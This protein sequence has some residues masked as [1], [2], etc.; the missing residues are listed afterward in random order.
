MLGQNCVVAKMLINITIQTFMSEN[1]LELSQSR[2]ESS[3]D[4]YLPRLYTLGLERFTTTRIWNKADKH[5]LAHVWEYRDKEAMD[6]CMPIWSEIE[7]TWRETIIMKTTSYRGVQISC[8][9]PDN[10]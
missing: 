3:K 4:K 5:S 2:W 7:A 8:D 10:K 9:A 6:N 1:E